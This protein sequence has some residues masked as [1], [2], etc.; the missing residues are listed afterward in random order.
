MRYTV[1]G[2]GGTCEKG[3]H[4]RDINELEPH[5]LGTFDRM[6]HSSS[7][8]QYS[9]FSYTSATVLDA[10]DDVLLSL[11]KVGM[12]A[13]ISPHDAGKLSLSGTGNGTNST[14]GPNGRDVYEKWQTDDFY[15]NDEAIAAYDRRLTY[16][17]NYTSPN[18]GRKWAQMSNVIAAF[19]I[20]NEPFLESTPLLDRLDPKNWLCGRARTIKDLTGSSGP[21]VATGA[22]G[23]S[24]VSF[25]S[26]N[27]A[28]FGFCWFNPWEFCRFGAQ[29][30]RYLGNNS[31]ALEVA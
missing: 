21:W 23:G 16:I 3:S 17:L 6:Y 10:I 26:F 8:R 12:K 15:T 22:V 11:S 27:F 20:Q 25:A 1:Q 2:T 29:A 9:W 5:A 7:G 19:D 28:H 31:K 18:F 24:C 14:Q 4:V 30:S 13:I